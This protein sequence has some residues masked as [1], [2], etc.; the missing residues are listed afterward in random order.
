MDSDGRMQ[1]G[2]LSLVIS[3]TIWIQKAE[4]KLLAG[5][6]SKMYGITSRQMVLWIAN[7]IKNIDGVDYQFNADGAWIEATTEAETT[8]Q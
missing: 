1:T 8:K 2:W 4:L 6:R 5:D 3:G 7:Q